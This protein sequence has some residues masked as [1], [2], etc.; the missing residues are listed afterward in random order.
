LLVG[1]SVVIYGLPLTETENQANHEAQKQNT[2][3]EKALTIL[4]D[5]VGLN[6]N[7]YAVEVE[8]KGTGLY[9][10]ILP[11]EMV[12]Y[13]FDAQESKFD[14]ICNFVEGKLHSMSVYLLR[15]EPC[16]THSTIDQLEAAKGFLDKYQKLFGAV[17]LEP[18]TAML[19]DVVANQN[20][21]TIC[22]NAKL[23]VTSAANETAIRWT[24]TANGV[25]APMK[26]AALKIENGFLTS[27]VDTWNLFTIASTNIEVSQE[28]AVE[29]AKEHAKNYSWNV[30]M[31]G[32]NPPVTVTEFKIVGD[33]QTSLTFGNYPFKN[34]SRIGNPLILYPGWRVKLFFD[35]LYPGNVYG[36]NVGVW[37]DT[38]EIHD[39]RTLIGGF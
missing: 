29:I 9:Y 35:K 11:Q 37:A 36:V 21:T 17:H 8:S 6:T 19:E 23:E 32:N 5:A 26:C 22:D 27:F 39:I 30:S 15:G 13:T 25:E 14:V 38:G 2:V 3:S 18:L 34:E 1:V 31:G 33:S 24:Y 4:N 28:E 16:L 7:S 10:E 12:K 20:L